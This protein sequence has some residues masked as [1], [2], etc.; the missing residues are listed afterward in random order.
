[1]LLE[2]LGSVIKKGLLTR[3]ENAIA[4]TSVAGG[5]GNDAA[6]YVIDNRD[7]VT[8]GSIE[9][10]TLVGDSEVQPYSK[11]AKLTKV[12]GVWK[13]VKSRRHRRRKLL[14]DADYNGLLKIQTLSNSKNM[15]IALAKAIR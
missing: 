9:G 6:T 5:M 11:G 8:D 4:G 1:V 2:D 15:Q 3:V 14:T 7:L 13:W 12:C 10:D